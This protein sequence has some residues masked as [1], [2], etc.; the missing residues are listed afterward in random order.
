MAALCLAT[1]QGGAG[2]RDSP[3]AAAVPVTTSTAMPDSAVTV[4][5]GP[6]SSARSI[7]VSRL[8]FEGAPLAVVAAPDPASVQLAAEAA[9]A[10][11]VPAL[12][13]DA[14]GL[15]EELDRLGART[16]LT[17]APT[18][19]G[20][21][22]ERH[23]VPRAPAV[24]AA[25]AELTGELDD[26]VPAGEGIVALTL[27][28][29]VDALAIATLVGS[30]VVPV[31][32]GDPRADPAVASRLRA[33]GDR[34]TVLLGD[35][36]IAPEY[37]LQVVR[38]A[39]EQPGGGHLVLPGRHIVALYGSPGTPALGL[40]GEQSP[41]ESAARAVAQANYYAAFSDRPVA[42]AFEIIATIAD[43]VAGPDGDYSLE[44]PVE[45][46][47]PWVDA[48]RDAGLYAILDLQP[49]RT[50]FLTQAQMY[51]ELLLEPHVGLAL[52]PEWRLAPDQVHLRQIGTV[53]GAEV[54]A[55]ADWLAALTRDHGLP[56][57]PFVLHQF[58]MS[59]ITGR[60][61]VR[62]DRP[63]LAT[64]IHVDGQGAPADKVG[65]W[66]RVRTGAPAGTFWGWKNFIDEDTPM[67][68]PEQTWEVQPRPDLVTYQ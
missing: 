35:G 17:I 29:G 33:A 1:V 30:E 43:A 34:P 47:R 64:I 27:D 61:E 6:D 31:P 65:T 63:E 41:Q 16:V 14:G 5:A 7:A 44:V 62:T 67:L 42:G 45:T 39:P 4:V 11:R 60:E 56:Q 55:V 21:D 26:P 36:W 48:A 18:A 40:L 24:D 50:D 38:S 2:P 8:V 51:T 22:G 12:G 46:I 9:A 15:L 32:G 28:P 25:V 10:L 59:M 19:V 3:A 54:N 53:S 68:T 57:K 58:T 37:T 52:D 49:G 13:A 66:D 23:V 20:L